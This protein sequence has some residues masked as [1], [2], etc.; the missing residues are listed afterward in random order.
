MDDR[1]D[2]DFRYSIVSF[3]EQIRGAHAALNSA[4]TVDDLVR[5]YGF[6]D[7]IL[8]DYAAMPVFSFDRAAALEFH[9]LRSSG[10]RVAATDLRIAAIALSQDLTL[11]TRNARDFAKVPNL[12]IE[13]W[14]N[15]A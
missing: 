15:R 5:A 4:R 11:L 2:A 1:P 6:F 12:R 7:M 9:R 8:R 3:D 10:L 14:T 13:D